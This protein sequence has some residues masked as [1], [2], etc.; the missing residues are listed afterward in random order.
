MIEFIEC[1]LFLYAG[2]RRSFR[3]EK[4]KQEIPHIAGHRLYILLL[5]F[6]IAF[7]LRFYL[8]ASKNKI[9]NGRK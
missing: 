2:D 1:I 6:S 9:D 4:L 8:A 7:V 3:F 5:F